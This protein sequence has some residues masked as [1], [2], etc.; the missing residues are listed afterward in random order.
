MKKPNFFI[1]GSP[2]CGTTALYSY[3][4]KHPNVYMP[5][6]KEPHFLSNEFKN[7]WADGIKNES[8]YLAL[9]D[10][11]KDEDIRVGEA[12][13][14][15]LY[16]TDAIKTIAE[17]Y[18][19]SKLI[20]MLRR[21]DEMVY[22]LHSQ[23]LFS[24]DE[25]ERDFEKAWKL[26]DA[27]KKGENIPK[28]CRTAKTLFYKDVAKFASQLKLM[29]KYWDKNNRLIILHDEFTRDPETQYKSVLEFLELPTIL[30]ETFAK[31]NQ[32]K[33]HKNKVIAKLTKSKILNKTG[34][35]LNKLLPFKLG[36][37]SLLK[38]KNTDH[39]RRK[40]LAA[41]SKKEIIEHYRD[42]IDELAQ[43]VNKDLSHW[44]VYD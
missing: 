7:Q 12:S 22:S 38:N 32:N 39:S 24:L 29:D 1:I 37:L 19:D 2:K 6:I 30:P 43:I 35:V 16:S 13:I 4:E 40:K 28:T 21:P 5:K 11:A 3:L 18:P 44:K 31:V 9:F 36:L 26:S 41:E 20:I 25:N 10:D 27:R 33:A 15:Y 23:K 17:K 34:E 8:D 42:E 14:W